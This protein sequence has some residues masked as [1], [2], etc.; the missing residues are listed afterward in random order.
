MEIIKEK[1]N[2][3]LVYI[4]GEGSLKGELKRVI[5]DK[6]LD[7]N[8]FLL[9]GGKSSA[10]MSGL[11]NACDI[12]VLPSL[13]EGNPTVMF[14]AMG[15]GKPFVGTRVGGIPDVIFSHDYGILVE[16]SNPTDMAKKILIAL[17]KEWNYV[18]IVEYAQRFAWKNVSKSVLQIY[19][20]I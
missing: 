9:G 5:K 12:F 8:I 16:P 18:A 10:E 15:C 13:A 17:D 4:I 3:I 7:N 20:M 14:E 19:N 6:G 11:I 2:D 1:R